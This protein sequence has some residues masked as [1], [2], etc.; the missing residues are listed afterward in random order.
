MDY[1]RLVQHSGMSG[2]LRTE[3]RLALPMAAQRHILS[4]EYQRTSLLRQ[5]P[6][7]T[8]GVNTIMTEL[9]QLESSLFVSPSVSVLQQSSHG[10]RVLVQYYRRMGDSVL[11]VHMNFV[12]DSL[13]VISQIS[14]KDSHRAKVFVHHHRSNG[15]CSRGH[16]L[17]ARRRS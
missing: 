16:S 4:Q 7:S 13:F 15:V 5:R 3:R 2:G 1:S 6:T 12:S 14:E 17:N 11:S 9:K 8:S 10:A